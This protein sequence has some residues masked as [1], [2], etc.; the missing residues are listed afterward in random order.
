MQN[1]PDFLPS[2]TE[3]LDVFTRQY[4]GFSHVHV[5]FS[6]GLDSTVL[7]HLLSQAP[8]LKGRLIAH[9]VHH[10]L[11]KSADDWVKHCEAFCLSLGVS[12]TFTQLQWTSVKREGIESVARRLRYQALTTGCCLDSDVLVTGHHQRD[13]A[14]TVLL[15][16]A[17]GA[18]VSGL[19]A[20]P[21]AK[22]LSTTTG[23]AWHC[24]PLLSTPYSMLKAYAQHFKLRWV[25]D[26]SNNLTYY[27]RNAIRQEVLPALYT[28]WPDVEKNL[29]RA[30]NNMAEAHTL[31]NRMAEQSFATM[32]GTAFYF[33]F[34]SLNYLD[35]L[36]Q[37][38]T[39]RYWLFKQYRLVLSARH[40]EWI[41][42][43][44]KQQAES[45]KNAFSYK[46]SQGVLCFYRKRLYYLKD[47]LL[48]YAWKVSLSVDG[49][50]WGAENQSF[51]L[52]L[53]EGKLCLSA[54]SLSAQEVYY[55]FQIECA[56]MA[57]LSECV[58][59]N[60]SKEDDLNRKKL[61]SFFQKNNIPT[62]ERSFWPVL[63][64]NGMMISVLGCVSCTN[65]IKASLLE[66]K[67]GGEKKQPAIQILSLSQRE[68]Y[69]LMNKGG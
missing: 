7:L 3:A 56:L 23:E 14:E 22:T 38:N 36:E 13:Q 1:S 61:K 60:I 64:F 30:A 47:R 50:K 20:M 24:R 26:P 42:E 16:L 39:L 53:D 6:G 18:G 17:R 32:K 2:F 10:G 54:S 44:L 41:E 33:D 58:V 29:A 49:E 21:Y 4:A 69:R 46:M 34:D 62:W 45:R 28:H 48:P 51:V 57:R 5:A 66:E 15:N 12:F 40:Y 27:R 25:E 9:H 8:C 37:K 68:C 52:R 59:R 35:W 67:G 65:K 31:L 11:Q 55:T 63:T 19:A 43:V